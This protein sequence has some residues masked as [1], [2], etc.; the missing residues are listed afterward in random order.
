[1]SSN[2]LDI[3]YILYLMYYDIS[4]HLKLMLFTTSVREFKSLF[5][6]FFCIFIQKKV[7]SGLE[8]SRRG[9]ITTKLI[10]APTIYLLFE[11]I[12]IQ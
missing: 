3:L 11:Y 2:T 8:P 12:Y 4:F 10:I 7:L 1:M 9:D 5:L 6:Y